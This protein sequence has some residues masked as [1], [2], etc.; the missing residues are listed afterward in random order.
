MMTPETPSSDQ[1]IVV[2]EKRNT[3]GRQR[4][5]VVL[6]ALAKVYTIFAPIIAVL[7]FSFAVRIWFVEESVETWERVLISLE[8]T[9]K[10]IVAFIVLRGAAQMIYLVFDIARG[11]NELREERQG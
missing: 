8:F 10:A 11:I 7:M 2:I 9:V 3:E 5:Y 1:A 6:R 4:P